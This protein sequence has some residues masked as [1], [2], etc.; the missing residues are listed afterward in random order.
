MMPVH[1]I[2]TEDGITRIRFSRRPTYEECR[3]AVDD[4]ADNYPYERRLWDFSGINFDLTQE[5]IRSIAH[6]GKVR[7]SKPNRAAIVAPNDLA[8]GEMRAFE[9]YRRQEGH[10]VARVFRTESEAVQWLR[11]SSEPAG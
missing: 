4:L 11:S 3:A 6:Y 1:S 7:F 8:Y 9:V 10:A 2:E 5:E